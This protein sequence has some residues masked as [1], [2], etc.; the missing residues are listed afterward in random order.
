MYT[1]RL[2]FQDKNTP[3]LKQKVSTK[4]IAEDTINSWSKTKAGIKCLDYFNP[5]GEK[6]VFHPDGTYFCKVAADTVK[7]L[8][9]KL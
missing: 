6:I 3:K 5:D 1:C 4:E 7:L 2:T 9:L 8:N